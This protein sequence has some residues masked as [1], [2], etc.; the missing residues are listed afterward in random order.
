[1]RSYWNVLRS[2]RT[3][4]TD[5]ATGTRLRFGTP[6]SPDPHVKTASFAVTAGQTRATGALF[7]GY[8]TIAREFGLPIVVRTD[9]AG[10]SGSVPGSRYPVDGPGNVNERCVA[11]LPRAAG[12][13]AR[14]GGNRSADRGAVPGRV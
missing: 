8:A 13:S 2:G 4:L 12:A 3:A 6:W 5:A 14:R 1:M 7:A 10:H 11:I 9:V